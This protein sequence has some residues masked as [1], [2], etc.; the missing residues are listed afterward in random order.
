MCKTNISITEIQETHNP[1]T[2]Q[3]LKQIGSKTII[4]WQDEH[5]E[6]QLGVRI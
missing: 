5:N 6:L 1:R 4:S 2:I 3:S